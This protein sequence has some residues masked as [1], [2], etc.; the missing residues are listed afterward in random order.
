[1]QSSHTFVFPSSPI[2][3]GS[4]NDWAARP[5]QTINNGYVFDPLALGSAPLDGYHSN[6]ATAGDFKDFKV[7]EPTPIQSLPV[8][9]RSDKQTFNW[10]A[11]FTFDRPH[12]HAHAAASR[13]P[14]AAPALKLCTRCMKGFSEEDDGPEVCAIYHVPPIDA[15]IRGNKAIY[16]VHYYQCCGAYRL[17]IPGLQLQRPFDP[18]CRLGAHIPAD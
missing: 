12:T 14:D 9:P 6:S 3:S 13:I 10:G 5:T 7:N 8:V 15:W 11:D 4:S 2:A 1:M 17:A 18:I 16:P